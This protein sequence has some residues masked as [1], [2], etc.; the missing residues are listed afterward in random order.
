MTELTAHR[1]LALRHVL[2]EQARCRLRRGASRAHASGLLPLRLDTCLELDLKSASFAAQAPGSMTA[3]RPRL[4][5]PGTRPGRQALPKEPGDCGMP[6]RRSTTT[7]GRPCLHTASRCRSMR[8]SKLTT[9][10]R[11]RSPTPTNCASAV[12]LDMAAAG[13]T[14]TVDSYLGRVTKARILAAV[15]EAKGER[16]ARLYRSPEEGRDG[17]E[18]G[19][20]ARRLGLAAGTAAHAGSRRPGIAKT[21]VDREQTGSTPRPNR[22]EDTA[23]HGGETAMAE[24]GAR[25]RG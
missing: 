6:S 12:D 10:G 7:A 3:C 2:G 4:S 14:P 20:P 18:G 1:T 13:W 5:P 21:D 23:E 17:R 9:G 15:R 16:A 25:R 8:C 24:T 19:S 22:L 11:A